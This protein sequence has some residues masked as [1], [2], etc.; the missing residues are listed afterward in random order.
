MKKHIT[1]KEVPPKRKD[2][3]HSNMV[4]IFYRGS[5]ELGTTD[6]FSIAY[7]QY[8]PPF[9]NKPKWVDFSSWDTNRIPEF[10]WELPNVNEETP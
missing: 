2:C 5:A 9:E 1:E 3:N 10:W 8:A 6:R 4:L 7:Y